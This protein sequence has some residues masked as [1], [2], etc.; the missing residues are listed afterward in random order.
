[1]QKAAET[2]DI[3]EHRPNKAVA[4]VNLL[5]KTLYIVFEYFFRHI[6]TVILLY[7]KNP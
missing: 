2:V 3:E 5:K 1:M 7:K 4:T 6:S